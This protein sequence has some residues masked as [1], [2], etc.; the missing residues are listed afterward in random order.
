MTEAADIGGALGTSSLDEV[1]LV[2]LAVAENMRRARLARGLSLR[3]MASQTGLSKALLSQI[4]REVANPTVA[5]LTRIAQALDLTFSEL[6]RSSSAEPLVI[7]STG[8]A[9][10]VSGARLL[11]TMMDRRRFDLS[12][13][14]LLPSQQGVFSD[15]G[16][17]SVEYG[18]VVSGEV[19]LT[20]VDRPIE[21]AAGDAVRFSAGLQHAYRALE[22]SATLLTVVAYADE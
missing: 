19:T 16:R 17:G 4:E 15:H 5:A 11:F 13:G 22:G 7:R 10:E 3:E 21:L 12:E 2:R 9:G 8:G 20:I 18:Y 14:I 1:A 6:T